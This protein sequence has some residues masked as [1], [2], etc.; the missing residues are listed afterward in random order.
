MTDQ[1][2]L[3]QYRDG[4]NEAFEQLARRHV[5]LVYSSALRQVHDPGLAQ[6]IAQRVFV[7]LAR[8]GAS[9]GPQ[10]VLGGWLLTA[11]RYIANDTR[12]AEFRR[13][14][15][16]QKA[17]QMK[18]EIQGTEPALWDQIAEHLDEA[19]G[20]L[21]EKLRSAVIL[22]YL[23]GKSSR[24][25]G[26]QLGISE[27]AA[28]QRVCRGLD[29]LRGFFSHK[30]VTL[31]SAS[32]ATLL[33]TH[34]ISPAPAAA[35]T[36][37][38]STAVHAATTLSTA[39]GA[40]AAILAAKAKIAS[41][42]LLAVSVVGGAGAIYLHSHP[43]AAPSVQVPFQT[44][45]QANSAQNLPPALIPDAIPAKA[46]E[47]TVLNIDGKPLPDTLVYLATPGH[48]FGV[49]SLRQQR[50]P[51]AVT[52]ADGGFV[53]PWDGTQGMLV[54][55][56]DDGFAS[57]RTK[58]F[59]KS[60]KIELRKWGSIDGVLKLG[61]KPL[62]GHDLQLSNWPSGEDPLSLCVIHEIHFKS[63]ADG[64]FSIPK[65]A[66][67]DVWISKINS[68]KYYHISQMVYLD[69]QPAKA[70]HIQVGGHGR[71]VIGKAVAQTPLVWKPD[72]THMYSLDLRRS[73]VSGQPL[74]PEWFKMTE[75]Q[76][77]E[78]KEKWSRTPEGLLYKQNMLPWAF[79]MNEDGTFRLDDIPAGKY[80][81]SIR[82]LIIDPKLNFADDLAGTMITITVPEM[83]G[84][85][86]DKP[87]DLGNITLKV[88]KHLRP[89]D[90]APDFALKTL[91]GDPIKLSDYRGKYVLLMFWAANPKQGLS[92][93][94]RWLEVYRNWGDDKRLV[95]LGINCDF[96]LETGKNY[97]ADHALPWT[98]AS[99]GRDWAKLQP[100]E[101]GIGS[102]ILIG[103]DGKLIEN[104]LYHDTIGKVVDQTLGQH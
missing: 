101:A 94:D 98:N 27:A 20:Q 62:G 41:A 28:R 13:R 47:G 66:P 78:Y 74:P 31:S 102:T 99:M 67:G 19:L 44:V 90:V 96:D 73:D 9:L 14:I 35:A 61:D 63:E 80:T 26:D 15:H 72:R 54:V 43:V 7:L 68:D 42:V 8:K 77:R 40:L 23:E 97:A 104:H 70:Y 86:D 83:A 24:E 69:V 16:E 4:S 30:G 33:A 17:A 34:A 12:K 21:G 6:D 10:V 57:I 29:Q 52:G 82:N 5:D 79:E 88:S 53:M 93:M 64:T 11:T 46:L 81:L 84:E 92:E 75:D 25:V 32:L 103:P 58:D 87:L 65:V 3:S 48:S 22:S 36:T 59:A 85:R 100:Y 37:I 38:V 49:Y 18:T 2:L 55:R 89:G 50:L 71:P 60:H 51:N 56:T 39:K 45:A 1:E 95:M 76:Q 91:G